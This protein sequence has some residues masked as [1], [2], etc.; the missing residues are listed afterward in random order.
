[1]S[2]TICR[3]KRTVM[4]QT[5]W[6]RTIV[7]GLLSPKVWKCKLSKNINVTVRW[8]DPKEPIRCRETYL[9]KTIKTL[10]YSAQ[11][12]LTNL[13]LKKCW[14]LPPPADSVSLLITWLA[15]IEFFL[16]QLA[17]QASEEK[18]SQQEEANPYNPSFRLRFVSIIWDEYENNANFVGCDLL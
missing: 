9:L 13:N 2:K 5:R 18:E 15:N 16:S 14:G 6:S 11:M 1:M 8:N 17:N 10:S 7:N 12:V 3:R 4:W